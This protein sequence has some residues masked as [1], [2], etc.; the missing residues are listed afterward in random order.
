MYGDAGLARD[1]TY[2]RVRFDVERYD[3]IVRVISESERHAAVACADVEDPK[4]T[5]VFARKV[6]GEPESL[7]DARQREATIALEARRIAIVFRNR[8]FHELAKLLAQH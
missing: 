8:A 5:L 2:E 6:R 4:R 3:E 1:L 7:V